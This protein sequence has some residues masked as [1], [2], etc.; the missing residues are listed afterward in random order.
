M[1]TKISMLEL[2]ELNIYHIPQVVK[3]LKST[4]PEEGFDDAEYLISLLTSGGFGKV[5][6]IREYIVGVILAIDYKS[7]IY[8]AVISVDPFYQN[9][10]VGKTML[11]EI[12]ISS[13]KDIWIKIN[14]CNTA[15]QSLF[16]KYNFTIKKKKDIPEPLK[17]S[18][19]TKYYPYCRKYKEVYNLNNFDL[20]KEII[21]LQDKIR[22][23][24]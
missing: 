16:K 1:T 6:I 13:S 4:L 20:Y 19:R 7:F 10:G 5:Y 3:L 23:L 15:S 9:R 12:I 21:E 2:V 17:K 18:Y 22:R 24:Y 11:E 8:I 14:Q